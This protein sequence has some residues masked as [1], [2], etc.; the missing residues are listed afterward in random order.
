[1]QN[2]GKKYW[3]EC[4]IC[5]FLPDDRGFLR[6]TAKDAVYTYEKQRIAFGMISECTGG[7]PVPLLL[8]MG[9]SSL[10]LF[11]VTTKELIARKLPAM[12]RA[13]AI[14]APTTLQKVAPTIFMNT[15]GQPV[16]MKLF[17]TEEEAAEWL[18]WFA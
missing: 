14:L 3:Y 2:L 11:D 18:K 17:D 15:M 5:S 6:I 12:F 7:Y 9:N 4:E 16:P 8:D 1:M 10:I 13:V